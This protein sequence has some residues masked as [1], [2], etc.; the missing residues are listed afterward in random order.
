MNKVRTTGQIVAQ[1]RRLSRES[2]KSEQTQVL[3]KGDNEG[4]ST[5]SHSDVTQIPGKRVSVVTTV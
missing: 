5:G 3:Y 1:D 2:V 4:E